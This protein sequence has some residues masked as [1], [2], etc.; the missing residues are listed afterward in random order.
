M[1]SATTPAPAQPGQEGRPLR[2]AAHG[3]VTCERCGLLARMPDSRAATQAVLTREY[4][5]DDTAAA[6]VCPRCMSPMHVRKPDSLA[7]CWALLIAAAAMYLPANL[8]PVMI[9]DTLLGTQQDTIM[10]GIVYLWTSG[11]WH[12]AI[13][14][15]IA[16]FLV[17]LAKLGIL[18]VLCLSVQQ[19]W[20]WNPRL[21][22]RLYA[23]VE[24]I[25]RWSMLDVFVV[26][27]LAGLVHLSTLAIIKPGP[28]V[29][30]FAAVVVLTMFAAR[31]FD[32]RLIWD[33]IDE[34]DPEET[35]V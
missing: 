19:R 35:D 28:G 2:A 32:P 13:I 26:T 24:I 34:P 7:R 5:P 25:G 16:S 4:A 8:L 12:L 1:K 33:V 27:L 21:R 20:R 10:S 22:T 3:L 9:T 6:P 29:G 11:S 23:L 15:F 18:A 30:P 14:V 17:P 31:C